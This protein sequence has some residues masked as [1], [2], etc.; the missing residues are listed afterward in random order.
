M[1]AD[2]AKDSA[3]LHI[4]NHHCSRQP[5]PSGCIIHNKPLLLA[6]MCPQQRQDLKLQNCQ[7]TGFSWSPV[8]KTL[9]ANFGGS[10]QGIQ[11]F[12]EIALEKVMFRWNRIVKNPCLQGSSR[13]TE[14]HV[15]ALLGLLWCRVLISLCSPSTINP[16]A[17]IVCYCC[18]FFSRG[19]G[20]K[21]VAE[22]TMTCAPS[23][24]LATVLDQLSLCLLLSAFQVCKPQS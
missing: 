22:I 17:S 23:C 5:Q 8:V 14:N 7:R 16:L 11:R 1:E 20:A 6:L 9:V 10:L 4:F 19:E 24:Y 18:F 12:T 21:C 13:P 2:G 3:G 15:V